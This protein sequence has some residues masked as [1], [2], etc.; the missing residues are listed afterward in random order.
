MVILFSDPRAFRVAS[1]QTGPFRPSPDWPAPQPGPPKPEPFSS[2]SQTR[3]ASECRVT[4]ALSDPRTFT[5]A[6][7]ISDP[8]REGP[9]RPLSSDWLSPSSPV[10]DPPPPS[11]RSGK[12]VK[13]T[14]TLSAPRAL[15]PHPQTGATIRGSGSVALGCGH[16]EHVGLKT[17]RH[18]CRVQSWGLAPNIPF[19]PCESELP[20]SP[21]P[22]S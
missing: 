8:V 4:Q 2:T 13:I 22:G 11:S 21:S 7:L 5:L 3:L 20:P 18:R 6:F 1:P 12:R 9:L 19:S 14:P 15:A 16:S 17:E 10:S